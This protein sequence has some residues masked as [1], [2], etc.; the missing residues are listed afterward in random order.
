ML[1]CFRFVWV[2]SLA[3]QRTRASSHVPL[4]LGK[5]KETLSIELSTRVRFDWSA[6]DELEEN[7]V[8]N[9]C[10]YIITPFCC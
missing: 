6:S 5:T 1:N 10:L 7:R 4:S 9:C 8:D 2:I 3:D